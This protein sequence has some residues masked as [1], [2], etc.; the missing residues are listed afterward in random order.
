MWTDGMLS[1]GTVFWS[2]KQRGE[3]HREKREQIQSAVSVRAFWR[4]CF[5][6]AFSRPLSCVSKLSVV[7]PQTKQTRREVEERGLL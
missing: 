5:V 7:F 6:R 2:K 3:K 1:Y 4:L